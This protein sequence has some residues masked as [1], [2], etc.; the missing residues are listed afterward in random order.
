MFPQKTYFSQLSRSYPILKLFD[1][2]NRQS[3]IRAHVLD[4]VYICILMCV[5]FYASLWYANNIIK[6]I[7]KSNEEMSRTVAENKTTDTQKITTNQLKDEMCR[8]SAELNT[9]SEKLDKLEKIIAKMVFSTKPQASHLHI[10][11]VSSHIQQFARVNIPKETR[12]HSRRSRSSSRRFHRLYRRNLRLGSTGSLLVDRLSNG[13][14]R[15]EVHLQLRRQKSDSNNSAS[16]E[17][18]S[19]PV[20]RRSI[21]RI[22]SRYSNYHDGDRKRYSKRLSKTRPRQ[23][24][25]CNVRKINLDTL[26][27]VTPLTRSLLGLATIFLQEHP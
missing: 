21:N 5:V 14:R 17:A 2:Y 6:R 9:T 1:I 26:K 23:F 11:P 20:L 18:S 3:F 25:C 27:N 4:N 13:D 10:Q 8:L 7:E 19:E 22:S 16:A 12:I 15:L 24:S